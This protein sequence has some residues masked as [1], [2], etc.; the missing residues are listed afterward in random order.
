MTSSYNSV[1]LVVLL[2]L[3]SG[4]AGMSSTET[5]GAD[6]YIDC[7]NNPTHSE[8]FE[9]VIVEDDCNSREIFT[10]TACRIMYRPENLNYGE[11]SIIL[12]VGEEMLVADVLLFIL[13]SFCNF[14]IKGP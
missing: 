8:C 10:G 14:P 6:D 7:T 4:C 3:S 5:I 13:L 9:S 1:F 2:M 11:S 12:L